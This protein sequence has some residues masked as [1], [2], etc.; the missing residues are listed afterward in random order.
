[1]NN[2]K[3]YVLYLKRLGFIFITVIFNLFNYLSPY[4]KNISGQSQNK[5]CA[6][7]IIDIILILD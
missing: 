6:K 7:R 3:S 5:G 4:K 1:M 2:L